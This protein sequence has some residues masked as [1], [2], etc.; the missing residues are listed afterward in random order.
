MSPRNAA[1][2]PQSPGPDG[3]PFNIFDVERLSG[4]EFDGH[5]MTLM[6]SYRF[7]TSFTPGAA[8]RPDFVTATKLGEIKERRPAADRRNRRPFLQHGG[9]QVSLLPRGNGASLSDVGSPWLC[10]QMRWR[11]LSSLSPRYSV[12]SRTSSIIDYV[13]YSGRKRRQRSP[14]SDMLLPS[15][16]WISSFREKPMAKNVI[17]PRSVWLSP[18][19]LS[20]VQL[21]TDLMRSGCGAALSYRIL[22]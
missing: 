4:C 2:T 15:P 11:N 21:L 17:S 19:P 14:R 7:E 1:C 12:C 8:R 13:G 9:Q 10:K 6:C 3:R 22:N 5:Q 18:A 16:G 20:L